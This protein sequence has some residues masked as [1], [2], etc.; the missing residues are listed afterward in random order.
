MDP[1]ISGRAALFWSKVDKAEGG[2]WTW[3]GS[4]FKPS[5]YGQFWVAGSPTIASRVA[6]CLTFGPIPDGMCVLHRCDNRP[7]VN[8][9][10]LFLGTKADNNRDRAQKGRNGNS[11][12]PPGERNGNASLT[13]HDVMK[14]R[15]LYSANNKRPKYG[16]LAKRFGIAASTVAAI[17]NRRTWKHVP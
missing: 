2:C 9:D 11:G 13:A 1:H 16:D 7:C 5:G 17:V 4:L 10:H 14:L 8:P 6:W 15:S 12:A 3:K